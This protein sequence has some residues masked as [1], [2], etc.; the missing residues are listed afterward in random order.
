MDWN[1]FLRST[2][3]KVFGLLLAA[4][5]LA[6]LF[7]ATIQI[8]GIV[9]AILY[10]F[11]FLTGVSIFPFSIALGGNALPFNGLI[12]KLHVMLGAFAFNH[13]YLVDMGDRWKWCPGEESRVYIDGQWYDIEG[14]GDNRS[15]LGWRP[16]GILRF[17][18]E[19]TLQSVRVDTKAERGR[20]TTADGG[21]ITRAGV[22]EKP[23]KPVTGID[24]EWL[25]DLKRVFSRGVKKIGDVELVET[26][27][28]VIERGE[29]TQSKI[30]GWKPIIGAIVGLLIGLPVFYFVFFG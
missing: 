10:W 6:G 5:V 27:E 3:V 2:Y 17:K 24:G 7:W 15:V 23:P 26:A 20:Q 19:D 22:A 14:G 21:S 4:V 25:I 13:H 29:V 28:E 1:A 12:G 11:L 8:A 30:E 16:F 9:A 18:T